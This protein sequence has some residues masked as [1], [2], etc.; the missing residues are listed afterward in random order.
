MRWTK[1]K[2]I[3]E[4]LFAPVV[5]GRLAIHATGYGNST[6]G[7]SWLTWD[8]QEIANFS[9]DEA[10]QHRGRQIHGEPSVITDGERTPGRLVEAGEFSSME[11]KDACFRFK[12]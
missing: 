8:G 2:S 10:F 5:A 7:R 4:S 11:F 3:V 1:L 12:D 9:D 6:W